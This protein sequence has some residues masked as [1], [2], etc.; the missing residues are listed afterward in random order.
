MT[1]RC[2]ARLL[3]IDDDPVV[4]SVLHDLLSGLGYVVDD[5]PGGAELLMACA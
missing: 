3:V 4:R 5:A 1:E 2:P